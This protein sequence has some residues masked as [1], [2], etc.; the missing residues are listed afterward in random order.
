MYCKLCLIELES[1][2][3]VLCELCADMARE[4]AREKEDEREIS[5]T[6]EIFGSE[7]A[8]YRYRND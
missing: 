8:Y 2:D 7:E 5:K 1:K 4:E 6:E 3:N